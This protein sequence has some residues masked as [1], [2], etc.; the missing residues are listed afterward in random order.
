MELHPD[1][2][3]GF[4]VSDVARLLRERFND[5]AASLGLTQAQARALLQLSRNEGISQV[6][7]ARLLEIQPITLLRQLDR[8]ADSGFIERRPNP[9]D[10]RAQQL[11]LTGS[12]NDLIEKL[13][14]LSRT[15]SVQIMEGVDRETLAGLM[16]GL[17]CIKENLL[18]TTPESARDSG[19]D[20]R[21]V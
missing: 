10:R 20:G 13:V 3:F 5:A 18:R 15:L 1:I 14:S 6:A 16:D 9:Q 7:L 8:L 4:L 11:Y 2:L 19:I 12:G 21:S 17:A